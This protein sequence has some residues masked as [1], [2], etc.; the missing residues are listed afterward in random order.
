VQRKE[1]ESR[2]TRVLSSILSA[3]RQFAI[4]YPNVG[5]PGDL[6]ALGP[7]GE[8]EEASEEHAGLLQPEMATNEFSNEGYKF[9]YE[10]IRGGPDRNFAVVAQP[11]DGTR[12]R[13]RNFFLDASG[14]IHV[15][16][17][18]RDATPEDPVE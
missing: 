18:N 11:I 9:R 6:G 1:S 2:I 17:E 12:P 5:F 4:T 15:T 3:V 10:L 7:A 14:S 13:G 8:D 16:D